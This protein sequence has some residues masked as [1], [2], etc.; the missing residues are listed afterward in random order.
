[1]AGFHPDIVFVSTIPPLGI[2]AAWLLAK[3]RKSSLV[4]WVMDINPDEA[5]AMGLVRPRSLSAKLMECMNREVLKSAKAV[6][7][8]DS[9][10]ERRIKLKLPFD[11]NR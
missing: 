8:L 1:M 4:Y 10:M 7:T 3:L 6:I 2:V 9:Y 5:I 11:K